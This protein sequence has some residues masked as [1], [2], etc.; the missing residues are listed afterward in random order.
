MPAPST[1]TAAPRARLRARAQAVACIRAFFA[2]EGL[3]EVDTPIAIQA[4][5]PEMYIDAPEVWLRTSMATASGSARRFLQ[6][7]P[8]LAMKQLLAAGSGPIYQLA[9]VFRDG[10][11]S[12][13]HRPEFRML[14]WYRPHR[15]LA[16][17]R[18]DCERLLRRLA[19]VL[20]GTPNSLRRGART[21]SLARPFA[22][23]RVDDAFQSH[24]GF[25]I[26]TALEIPALFAE[27]ERLGLQPQADDSWDDLYHRIWLACIEPELA[28]DGRPVFITE[29][30]A[31]RAS[32]ARLDP[33]DP[34]IAQRFELYVGGLE[35]ANAF[36]ELTDP[37]EQR[38]RF[39][40]ER[41]QRAAAGRRDYPLDEAFLAALERMPPTSGIALGLE[42]LLM[43][44][45]DA[46]N[47]DQVASL[48]WN[49]T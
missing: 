44:V 36:A 21:L 47:I 39:V 35:L 22:E 8:E 27:A 26:L 20:H 43:V 16:D 28:A 18:V 30:P 10:D 6:T 49:L 24:A 41:A 19:D 17:L 46:T 34:R 4:P 1:A 31:P 9:A 37:I 23:L 7:S 25:S 29:F 11:H 42:R 2:D 15:P 13:V 48:P 45:L 38:R 5:A 33:D 40:A 3:L 14:E 32:L 12:P